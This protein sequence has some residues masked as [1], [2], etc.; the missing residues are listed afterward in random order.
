MAQMLAPYNNAMRLG[1]GF[2]SYTQKTCIDGAVGPKIDEPKEAVSASQKEVS[3]IVSYSS[4]FV[5]KLSDITDA[6]NISAS[7]SIK[8]SKIGGSANGAF[9]DSDKFKE[10]DLN[11]FIQVKVVN[12][13]TM[14]RNYT[15]F[16]KIDVPPAQFND[17]YG[18]CFISGWEEGGELNALLS[19][20]C[21]DKSKKQTIQAQLEAQLGTPVLSGK[22]TGAFGQEGA[23]TN[24][25]TETT[26][27]VNWSGGGK[28]K[29]EDAVWDVNSL[30][31]AAANFPDKVM[32]TPQRTYAILT[33]YT[34]LKSFHKQMGGFTP[35]D[36]ESAGIYTS[37]LLD[38]YMDYKSIWK[39]IQVATAEL[40]TGQTQLKIAQPSGEVLNYAPPTP[41]RKYEDSIRTE[42]PAESDTQQK[43]LAVPF[44]PHQFKIAA[45]LP[46]PLGLDKAR[47]DCRLE[48]VKIVHEVDLVTRNPA[49]ALEPDRDGIFLSSV[50]FKQL[51]PVKALPPPEPSKPSIP[52]HALPVPDVPE[53]VSVYMG[54]PDAPFLQQAIQTH[55]NKASR[56][57]MST[58]SGT[59]TAGGNSFNHL[60]DIDPENRMKTFTF[61]SN[62]KWV[63]HVDVTFM[64]GTKRTYGNPNNNF[65]GIPSFATTLDIS[66]VK[67]VGAVI[68]S[69]GLLGNTYRPFKF[70]SWLCFDPKT[71]ITTHS[72]HIGT[73][74]AAEF[75]LTNSGGTVKTHLAPVLDGSWSLWGFYGN[76]LTGLDALGMVWKKD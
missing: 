58:Y 40:E 11:F 64:D 27:S 9:I 72:Q 18:D 61:N 33:K 76:A 54:I 8:T 74:P 63:N 5:E 67:I 37:A 39:Q 60:D 2:N 12:Q 13:S 52:A 23:E 15:E 35:L 43:P 17:V 21:K 70:V 20:K 19:I 57:R 69:D 30:T 31:L 65:H 32:M 44:T 28:L 25:W 47:R 34:A 66:K 36:Y 7:L 53:H 68:V 56:F 24:K 6:M 3:Q 59:L 73:K 55:E 51:L 46:T 49:I 38:S 45:Y 50:I 14:A 16:E 71:G 10:S 22:V 26:I 42:P 41:T 75:T 4:R 29:K 1:Q 62:E 48:M